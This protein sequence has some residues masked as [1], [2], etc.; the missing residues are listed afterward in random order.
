MRWGRYTVAMLPGCALWAALYATVGFAALTAWLT[1]HG[2]WKWV[3]LAAVILVVAGGALIVRHV[4][5]VRRRALSP[6]V[7][8]ATGQ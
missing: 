7:A 4:R 8:A 3:A 6:A 1:L 5:A 2:A